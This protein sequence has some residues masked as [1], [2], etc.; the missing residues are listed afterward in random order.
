[1][2]QSFFTPATQQEACDSFSQRLQAGDYMASP[3]FGS[4]SNEVANAFSVN[5]GQ[6]VLFAHVVIGG[7]PC[8]ALPY[9]NQL[10]AEA[11]SSSF[12]QLPHS[13]S[14]FATVEA[15]QITEATTYWSLSVV[16]ALTTDH[17]YGLA[18]PPHH[19][20]FR[21]AKEQTAVCGLLRCMPTLHLLMQHGGQTCVQL[22]PSVA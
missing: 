2:T 14:H 15:N 19:D 22:Q 12:P 17:W 11:A 1:M 10:S 20:T 16:K 6:S 9:I 21:L 18:R 13:E 8:L 3:C 4:F 5:L 7:N